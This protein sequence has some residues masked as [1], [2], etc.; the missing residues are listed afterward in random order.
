MH[1]F[2]EENSTIL[3]AVFFGNDAVD[4]ADRRRKDPDRQQR[5]SSFVT[6]FAFAECSFMSFRL[7]IRPV[8]YFILPTG[9]PPWK[10]LLM[11][12]ST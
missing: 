3:G 9:D 1:T 11:R 7:S 8:M 5:N 10:N 2:I 12:N 6:I 4:R